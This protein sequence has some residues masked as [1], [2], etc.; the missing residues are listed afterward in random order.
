GVLHTTSHFQGAGGGLRGSQDFKLPPGVQELSGVEWGPIE[1]GPNYRAR[2]GVNTATGDTYKETLYLDKQNNVLFF[3]RERWYTDKDGIRHK[4]T[5]MPNGDTIDVWDGKDLR[6]NKLIT[7]L[8]NGDK[9]LVQSWD[10]G[11]GRTFHFVTVTN[12]DGTKVTGE[13]YGDGF[14]VT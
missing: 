13:D 8:S 14:K 11:G 10:G 6:H 4:L 12:S 9:I 3:Q 1:W 5:N 7:L 2:T